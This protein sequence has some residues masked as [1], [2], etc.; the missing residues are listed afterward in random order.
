MKKYVLAVIV[1]ASFTTNHLQAQKTKESAVPVEVK[2]AFSKTYPKATKV[3][4]EKEKGDY[5][6]SFMNDKEEMLVVMGKT[7]NVLETEK[8]IKFDQLP[9]K[10]Q[11]ALKG[12][13]VSECATIQ[14]DGK[15]LYEAEVHGKDLLFNESGKAL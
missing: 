4:W 8:T 12:K 3:K 10:V 15:T 6:A 5:E 14:K 11:A 1:M 7:G 13:K 2:T 9:A